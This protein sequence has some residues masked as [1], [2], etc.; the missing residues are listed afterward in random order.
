MCGI[1]GVFDA[2][3]FPTAIREAVQRMT[4]SIV[5]RA[6]LTGRASPFADGIGVR[7]TAAKPHSCCGRHPAT[8]NEDDRIQVLMNR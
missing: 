5:H 7:R 6:I 8:A 4:D 2:R 1:A 3:M